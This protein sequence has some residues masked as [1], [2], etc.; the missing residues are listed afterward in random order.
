MPGKISAIAGVLCALCV[1]GCVTE[2][3]TDE[4]IAA[5]KAPIKPLVCP[6]PKSMS[7]DLDCW[8]KLD[9]SV[10]VVVDCPDEKASQWVKRYW[11]KWFMH[12][13]QIAAGPS[14]GAKQGSVE[15]Y[16]LFVGK[17][18]ISIS[19]QGLSGV[20]YAMMTL[21]QLA[22]ANRGTRELTHYIAPQATI[23]DAPL[24]KW[25]GLHLCWFPE[26]SV[27]EV[28]RFI[29]MAAYLKFQYVILESWGVFRSDLFPWLGWS[30]G[31]MTKKEIRRLKVIADDLGVTL[32]PQVNVLGHASFSRGC[33]GKHSTLD[34]N[35]AYQPLF[36][37]VMGWNWCLTNPEARKVLRLFIQEIHDAFGR[38]PYMHLGCDE[39]T[40][41]S[42]PECV[43]GNYD[44]KIID[45]IRYMSEA[46]EEQGARAIIWHDMFLRI[47]DP[48][49]PKDH[50]NGSTEMVAKA[51]ELPRSIVIADWNYRDAFP[52]GDYPSLKHFHDMGF[53]VLTCP[54]DSESGIDAQ[55]RYAQAN[56]W[57]GFLG[58]TWHHATGGNLR[59]MFVH[60]AH[61]SWGGNPRA[62]RS[63]WDSRIMTMLRHVQWDMENLDYESCGVDYYQVAPA[64]APMP[65]I[66]P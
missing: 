46:I 40:P 8:V 58:T 10:P 33:T 44:D 14:A 64:K 34:M 48:R 18:R 5:L 59:T 35:S 7:L 39:A 61:A 36:E 62:F 28:E 51:A 47:A 11:K 27:L 31:K 66:T 43:K 29:R 17:D 2:E 50:R 54:W 19:S 45:H 16:R 22:I 42:C 65:A 26:M 9:G 60:D 49:F 21:R 55:G 41:P 63:P 15:A 32:I 57:C 23:E 25:R 53:D 4:Q 12:D 38:P 37:P 52:G 56:P 1:C 30:D 3:F 6:A 13:V 20:R 24:L